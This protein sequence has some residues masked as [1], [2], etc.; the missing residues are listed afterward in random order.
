MNAT[1]HQCEARQHS[2]Q[3]MCGRCGLAYDV[4]D[5]DPPQCPRTLEPARS[6]GA[7]RH[8]TGGLV[9]APTDQIERRATPRATLAPSSAASFMACPAKVPMYDVTIPLT[10]T[11]AGKKA[12]RQALAELKKVEPN[13]TVA[14]PGQRKPDN[15]E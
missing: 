11:E 10:V 4:N 7:P 3:M 13:M 6:S 15:K 1:T 8:H 12:I 2:D 9:P 5:P 14:N